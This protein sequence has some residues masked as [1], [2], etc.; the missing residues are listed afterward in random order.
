MPTKLT[1][2]CIATNL[3]ILEVEIDKIITIQNP[4]LIMLPTVLLK[5]EVGPT[6]VLLTLI[7]L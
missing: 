7:N 2:K 3:C 5:D 1:S 4:Q 6:Q